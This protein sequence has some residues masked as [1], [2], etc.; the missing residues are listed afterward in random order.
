MTEQKGRNYNP[1]R[2]NDISLNGLCKSIFLD[3]K[4]INTTFDIVFSGR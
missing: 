3:A 2:K 4:K 1:K